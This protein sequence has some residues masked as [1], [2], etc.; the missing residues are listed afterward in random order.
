MS[1]GH[2]ACHENLSADGSRLPDED[3]KLRHYKRGIISMANDG[4][5]ANGHEF[6]ISLDKAEYLDGYNTVFGE[7]VEGE[8]TLKHLE[9]GLTRDGQIKE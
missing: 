7:L 9:E 3:L 1:A 5:N 4:D 6:Y 8:E 2:D